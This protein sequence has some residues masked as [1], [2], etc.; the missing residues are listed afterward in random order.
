MSDLPPQCAVV[1]LPDIELIGQ[2]NCARRRLVAI[3]PGFTEPVAREIAKKWCELGANA[4]Y[5]ILDA[6]PEVC[7]LGF[8]D[9]AALEM[10]QDTAA[11]LH[12]CIHQQPGLRVG[13]II[14]DE[15]TTVYSPAPRLIEAGGQP[16]ERLNALRL[17]T[18][19]LE[20]SD[21]DATPVENLDLHPAPVGDADVRATAQD[22][23]ANPPLKFDLARTLRVFN[24]FFEFVEFE[25]HG[26]LLEKR[27]VPIPSDLLGL[28][29]D[30]KTQKLLHSSFQLIA[31]DS[32][33][34]GSRVMRLKQWI[35]ERYVINLPGY[36]NVVRRTNKEQFENAVKA[37]EKYVLRFQRRL[38][39]KLQQA[40][41]ANREKLVTMLLPAVITSPPPRWQRYIGSRPTHQET[42]QMLRTELEDIFGRADDLFKEMKVKVIF[43]GVTYESL[44]DPEFRKV[45]AAKIPG[46][47]QLHEE[48]EVAKAAGQGQG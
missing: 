44:N 18:S 19:I 40:I 36:G 42:E 17:D 21:N 48:F 7:R 47:K 6:D 33:V 38:K 35:T 25:L 30:P 45:A 34:S 14:T 43:K 31:E 9:L 28:A 29:K 24:A 37:L 4:V 11:R 5:V 10:L 41:D 3:A 20:R 2:I 26:L 8:G 23:A 12:T 13:V 46:L 1:S 39:R 15:T 22:L 27:K 16:G 32:D